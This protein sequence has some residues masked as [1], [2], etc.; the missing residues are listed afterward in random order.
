MLLST[1]KKRTEI[2]LHSSLGCANEL[3]QL[4][5]RADPVDSSKGALANFTENGILANRTL[6]LIQFVNDGPSR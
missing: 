4:T 3:K 2:S 5:Y 1:I 6:L